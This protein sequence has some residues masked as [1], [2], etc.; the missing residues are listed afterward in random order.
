MLET[1]GE[2]DLAAARERYAHLL[3]GTKDLT[4]LHRILAGTLEDETEAN[5][6]AQGRP[7]WHPLADSTKRARLAR[8]KGSSVLMILQD[9]G[10]LAKSVSSEYGPDF[11]LIG[12]GGA[13]SAY[14]AAQQLGV[15]IN[16]PTYSTKVRLRTNAKGELLRQGATGKSANLAVFA[17]DRH[18]RVRES[19]HQVP[20]YSFTL[21]AR[22]YLPFLGTGASATLQPAAEDSVLLAMQ[23]Y[24]DKLAA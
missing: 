4:P 11:A 20:A 13:A 23:R 18:K 2:I 3:A 10:Y 21:P 7:Q 6:A 24:I 5:F 22:P 12:A 1:S 16:R 17:K 8:N 14:A 19:W 15:T 9:H